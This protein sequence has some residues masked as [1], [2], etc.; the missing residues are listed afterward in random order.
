MNILVVFAGAGL[1][2]VLRFLMG[3]FFFGLF[4][5]I[6]LGTLFVNVLGAVLS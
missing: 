5:R 4:K 2:G 6:W 1:G 3:I